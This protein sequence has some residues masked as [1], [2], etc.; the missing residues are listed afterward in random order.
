MGN[1][2]GGLARP[3]N[4]RGA[5]GE[6]IPVVIDKATESKQEPA[7]YYNLAFIIIGLFSIAA[8]K[9]GLAQ[10]SRNNNETRPRILSNVSESIRNP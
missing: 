5:I 10:C 4:N 1:L 2:F 6:S 7:P 3:G 9:A 8:K